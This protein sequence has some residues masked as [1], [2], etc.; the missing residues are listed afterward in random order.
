MAAILGRGKR[1]V[2]QFH[3]AEKDDEGMALKIC[4]K[5][6]DIPDGIKSH[7]KKRGLDNEN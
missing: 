3:R 7:K 2:A 4:T 5:A 1:K 6:E